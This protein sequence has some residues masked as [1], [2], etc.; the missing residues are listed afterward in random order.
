M[1]DHPIQSNNCDQEPVG[2]GS[3]TACPSLGE[4]E[5]SSKSNPQP[6]Q[7]EAWNPT[8]SQRKGIAKLHQL[9]SVFLK[10]GDSKFAGFRPACQTVLAIGASGS[11]KTALALR[12]AAE[13]QVPL[14]AL[15]CGSWLVA[16]AAAK[17]A[18]LGL[19]RDFVRSAPQSEGLSGIIF[20]DELC[21]LVPAGGELSRNGWS[22]SVC[23]EAIAFLSADARLSAHGFTPGDIFRLRNHFMIIGGGAFQIAL[24]EVEAATQKGKLGF[25]TTSKKTPTH[26][27]AVAEYLPEEILSRFSSDIIVL[28][29]PNRGDYEEA[30]QRIHSQLGIPRQISMSE[31]VD[32]ATK[33]VGGMRW[34]ENYLCGLLSTHPYA[35][36]GR[37]KPNKETGSKREDQIY[38]ITLDVQKCQQDEAET[39]IKLQTKLALVYSRLQCVSDAGQSLPQGCVLSNPQFH[40]VLTDAITACRLTDQVSA[41]EANGPLAMWR[42]VA[43][44]AL[45][46][47]SPFLAAH[48][49]SETWTEA[50]SMA[51]A[52][53]DHRLRLLKAIQRGQQG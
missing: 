33:G 27:R 17:P 18:T 49:L 16:G 2:Q 24:R 47:S 36:R 11:G 28:E 9:A 15:D 40:T 3:L 32:D 37:S 35:I 53:I 10:T 20:A 19:V 26:C 48:D 25:S 38:S 1:T 44:Q 7:I 51:G 41:D 34:C 12:F 8:E 43:W 14:M 22:L 13:L 50:W 4:L 30:I 45:G 42:D 21:K 6:A 46:E 52:L 29:T 23:A 31:L 39:A 5:L